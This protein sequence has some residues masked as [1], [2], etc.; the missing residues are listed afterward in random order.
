[1][2]D[3][4]RYELDG[5]GQFIEFSLSW[6][7]GEVRAFWNSNDEEWLALLRSKVTAIALGELDSPEQLTQD[8]LDT[9]DYGVFAWLQQVCVKAVTDVT[10]LGE[11]FGRRLWATPEST[12]DTTDRPTNS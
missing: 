12:T 4:L 7:R 9:L 1:M 5:T 3:T 11:A 6:K 2:A 8:G 10:R